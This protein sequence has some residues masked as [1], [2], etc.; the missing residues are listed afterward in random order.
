[1]AHFAVSA[2]GADRPGIVASVTGVLY[3]QGCNVEDTEMSVLRGNFAMMMV[4]SGPDDLTAPALEAALTEAAVASDLVVAVRAL[5]DAVPVSPSGSR[6][7][8][9]VYGADKPG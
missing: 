4:I 9:A 8:V 2:V 6:W 3:E 7:S 1:M 5:D